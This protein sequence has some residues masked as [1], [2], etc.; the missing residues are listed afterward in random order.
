MNLNKIMLAGFFGLSMVSVANAADGTLNITG[1]IE[2]TACVVDAGDQN[3]NIPMGAISKS[4]FT[5]AGAP[6][7]NKSFTIAVTGCAADSDVKVRFSGSAVPGSPALLQLTPGATTAQGVAV[8]LY[9]ISGAPVPLNTDSA[10]QKTDTSGAAT[11]QYVAAYVS[12]S[13]A[14]IVSGGADAV[15]TFTIINP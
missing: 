7:G 10:P 12:P 8:G 9:E 5:T 3:K 1:S 14:S 4:A 2:D 11:L 13:T 15:G 6:V